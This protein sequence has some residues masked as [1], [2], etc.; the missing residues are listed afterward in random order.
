M[1]GADALLICTEWGIFRNP[2]FEKIKD[3]LNDS[4]IFDGRNLFDIDEMNERGFYY[5]SIGR[6]QIVK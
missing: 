3:L 4:V 5:T 2:D 1:E 6:K